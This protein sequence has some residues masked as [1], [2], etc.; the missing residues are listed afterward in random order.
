M[1]KRVSKVNTV[2]YVDYENVNNGGIDGIEKLE[3]DCLVK[4]LYSG[5]ADTMRIPA[6]QKVIAARARVEF[7]EV[8]V[9]TLNALDFQLIA[10]LY[11]GIKGNLKYYIVSKDKGYDAAIIRGEQLGWGNVER[12]ACIDEIVPIEYED[13]VA[14]EVDQSV[15]KPLKKLEGVD[16]ELYVLIRDRCHVDLCDDD[17]L[18]I[19]AAIRA[20]EEGSGKP[21]SRFYLHLVQTM[22]QQKGLRLYDSIKKHYPEIR[23]TVKGE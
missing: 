20:S 17:V 3:K 8:G 11:S 2:I 4:I 12:I 15:V 19:S 18:L 16:Y 5:N 13:E 6:I 23:N 7:I 1:A 10:D 9:S 21:K 14:E 22:G